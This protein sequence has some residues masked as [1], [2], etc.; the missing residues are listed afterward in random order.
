M[1]RSNW[2]PLAGRPVV[3]LPTNC[4]EGRDFARAVAKEVIPLDPPPAVRMLALPGLDEGD[5]IGNFGWDAKLSP[6]ALGD[7]VRKLA[8][9]TPEMTLA[10][11]LGFPNMEAMCDPVPVRWL[12][13]GRVPIGKVTVIFGGCNAGKS[14]VALNLAAR[15]SAGA[16][17]PDGRGKAPRGKVMLMS[18]EDHLGDTVRPRLDRAGAVVER[19]IVLNTVTRVTAGREV[20][21]EM[22]MADQDDLERAVQIARGVR[23][24]VI[25]PLSAYFDSD[26]PSRR[27]IRPPIARLTDLAE[28]YALAVIVTAEMD[29]RDGL[30]FGANRALMSVVRTAW[31]LAPV[32]GPVDGATDAGAAETESPEHMMLVPLKRS[33]GGPAGALALRIG[34]NAVEW[35][36]A[37]LPAINAGGMAALGTFDP[38]DRLRAGKLTTAPLAA[39]PAASLPAASLPAASLPAVSLSNPPNPSSSSNGTNRLIVPSPSRRSAAPGNGGALAAGATGWRTPSGRKRR[40]R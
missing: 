3:L 9:E 34:D 6:A 8:A 22:T 40:E 19:I 11:T 37:P 16:D 32:P 23:L 15:V 13:P 5:D 38:F 30:G 29:G 21:R 31:M 12:W 28:R 24:V 10:D 33:L 1:S 7:R 39:P 35:A 2:R 4:Q 18:R 25:D 27:R 26:M 20:R 17:W 36:P 14:I